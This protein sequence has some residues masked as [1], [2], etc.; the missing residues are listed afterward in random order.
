MPPDTTKGIAET[1]GTAS[2]EAWMAGYIAHDVG[3]ACAAPVW[4][5]PSDQREWLQGW[6]DTEQASRKAEEIKD[7]QP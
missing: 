3:Q 5:V 2:P 4:F 7:G 1:F 6:R